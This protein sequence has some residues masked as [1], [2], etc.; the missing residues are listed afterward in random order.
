MSVPFSEG[1]AQICHEANRTYCQ[2]V[3]D[4]SQATW[5]EAP[6]WQQDS[7]IKGVRFHLDALNKGI[8]PLASASHDSWLEEKR[9]DGWQYGPVKNA[10]TKRHPC[11]V[12]YE[13]LPFEQRVKDYLFGAI[14]KAF[15]EADQKELAAS[16]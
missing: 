10:E 9:R 13:Q 8:I 14:V 16:A 12:P 5:A 7:A 3:G 15:W 11:F 4:N 2:T 1:I 6:K